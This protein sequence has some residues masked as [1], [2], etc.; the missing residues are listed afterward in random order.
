MGQGKRRIDA[1]FQE[2]SSS[3]SANE[4]V[5]NVI[6][7]TKAYH[8]YKREYVKQLVFT[9]KEENLSKYISRYFIVVK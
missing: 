8:E 3:S 5:V 7:L 6:A 1:A 2:S 9:P 4:D